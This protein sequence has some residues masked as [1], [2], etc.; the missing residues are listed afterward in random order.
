[1]R[2][3]LVALGL[4]ALP[5]LAFGPREALTYRPPELGVLA[6]RSQ[7]ASARADY[8]QLGLSGTAGATVQDDL[9][10]TLRLRLDLSETAR[11]AAESD[12]KKAEARLR[13]ALRDGVYRALKAHAGLW[14][15]QAAAKAARAQL[16]AARLRLEPAEKRGG[17]LAKEAAKN[18]L[19]DAELARKL[20]ELDLKAAALEARALD[21]KGP[22]EPGTLRFILP[23]PRPDPGKELQVQLAKAQAAA[24]K[25]GLFTLRLALAYQGEL[26]YRLEAETKTPSL[27]LTL[28]P[29]NP[30]AP[31]GT[32]KA[33]LSAQLALDPAAWN[34]AEDAALAAREAALAAARQGSER[35]MRLKTL[36]S[37]ALLLEKRLDL[38]KKAL[39]LATKK[40][41]AAR[42]RHERG[43][44]SALDLARE[45]TNR[46]EA[47]AS[48]A[49][50]WGAYL[51]AVKAYLD[52]ADG[53]WR[54]R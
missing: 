39:D 37:R 17:L 12:R 50:A 36:R 13:Q 10:A 43:L 23:A 6:A 33:E 16:S 53:E 32:W 47:E 49:Q 30:L 34:R 19:E 38:A 25:R 21:L 46:D 7:L 14:R 35:E 11:L 29:K 15:A 54:E 45:A 51:D 41:A 26:G 52:L 48:L 31:P 9:T 40:L 2:S 20:A 27:A 18:G 3:V 22:A 4:L 8:A 5:A 44:V 42:L 1:M 24:A 28:G